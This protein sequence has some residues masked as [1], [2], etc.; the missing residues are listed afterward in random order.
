MTS[1]WLMNP[2]MSLGTFLKA[3]AV[4]EIL[5]GQRFDTA[6]FC[7]LVACTKCKLKVACVAGV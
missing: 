7:A 4:S 5:S 2:E 1:A 6:I 3:Q